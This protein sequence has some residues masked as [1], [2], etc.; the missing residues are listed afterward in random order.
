MADEKQQNRKAKQSHSKHETC[1][2][3]TQDSGL[4]TSVGIDVRSDNEKV[5][6]PGSS[7]STETVSCFGGISAGDKYRHW[8]TRELSVTSPEVGFCVSGLE[9]RRKNFFGNCYLLYVLCCLI[10]LLKNHCTKMPSFFFSCERSS[11]V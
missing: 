9:S 4:K 10:Y 8:Q 6:G 7:V 11:A 2:V 1:V 3:K 5:S